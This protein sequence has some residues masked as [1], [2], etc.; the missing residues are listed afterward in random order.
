MDDDGVKVNY[1]AGN[2]MDYTQDKSTRC[3]DIKNVRR[4]ESAASASRTTATVRSDQ[5]CGP[6]FGEIDHYRLLDHVAFTGRKM[7]L[8]C[9]N[10][11]GPAGARGQTDAGEG[12]RPRPP[13]AGVPGNGDRGTCRQSGGLDDESGNERV[14]SIRPLTALDKIPR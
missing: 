10:I 13:G 14:W 9:E 3:D 7:P 6:G 12:R 2:V 4:A 8:C 5:D 1:D 11:F